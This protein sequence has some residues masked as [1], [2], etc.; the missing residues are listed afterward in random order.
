MKTIKEIFDN[1]QQKL[2]CESFLGFKYIA[3]KM[4]WD[5][6]VPNDIAV[7]SINN[8]ENCDV[9]D[10]Y[11]ICKDAP[12]VLNLDFDDIDPMHLDLDN[13]LDKFTYKRN[14]KINTVYFFTN[15]MAEKS[16]EFIER[17]K[18]KHFFIHCSAGIS[19]S[20]AFVRFIENTYYNKKFELNPLNPCRYPNGHVYSKLCE[21]YRIKN[22]IN[23][24]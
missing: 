11:H 20:Q 23:N 19:R 9:I 8:S 7:I 21:A 4:E 22:N 3:Y 18:D 15:S 10:E 16:I 6:V 5:E 12:N 17:N 13:N 1:T 14:N 24:L 2:W